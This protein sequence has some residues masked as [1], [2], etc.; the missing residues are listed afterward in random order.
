MSALE[1]FVANNPDMAEQEYGTAL[2]A[3]LAGSFLARRSERLVR[4][5]FGSVIGLLVD[6]PLTKIG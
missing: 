6:E 3:I 4:K 5:D 2:A 1:R